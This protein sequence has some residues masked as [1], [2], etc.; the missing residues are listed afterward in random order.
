MKTRKDL[1]HLL[2]DLGL[3]CHGA[4][5][6]VYKADFSVH[7]LKHWKGER[8]YLVDPW[9]HQGSRM[10]KSDVSQLK[11]DL[12]YQLA[13][14][15]MRPF[16]KRAHIIR[17]M[18]VSAPHALYKIGA[19]NL[20]FVYIDARHDYRSVW[21]DLCIWW[22]KVRSGG[23]IAGHDY[24]N[25]CVRNNLVEVKRAVDN[26]FLA[27]GFLAEDVLSTSEDNLPTWYVF[28]P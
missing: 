12:I 20:D 26:F 6:G 21:D 23:M 24:K 17:E 14:E 28:K 1:P 13:K 15:K 16:K 3:T 10:D 9:R 4:E 11:Q 7:L 22:P 5:I 25:S 18:S 27:E 8:L 19:Y 2:N